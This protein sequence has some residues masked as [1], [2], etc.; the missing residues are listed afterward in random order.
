MDKFTVKDRTLMVNRSNDV[1]VGW[2]HALL[3]AMDL[4]NGRQPSILILDD[5]NSF[6][7]ENV[8]RA[9]IKKLYGVLGK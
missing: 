1:V 3:L 2:I 4:P 9:F 7:N 8:N 6:G 5:F